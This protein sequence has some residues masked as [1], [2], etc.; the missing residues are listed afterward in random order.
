MKN[1]MRSEA[2]EKKLR[3]KAAKLKLKE[4]QML[5]EI[6]KLARENRLPSLEEVC[7]VV[8]ETKIAYDSPLR[9]AR[10]DHHEKVWIN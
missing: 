5:K 1:K 3:R 6:G 10:R 8:A 4:R 9:K 7:R 2:R